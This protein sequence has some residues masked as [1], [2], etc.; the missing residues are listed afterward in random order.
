MK[1]STCTIIGK[2]TLSEW[3]NKW[4]LEKTKR[5]I[6]HVLEWVECSYR[7]VDDF[8]M[9]VLRGY[10]FCPEFGVLGCGVLP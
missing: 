10:G 4:K 8:L 2:E 3:Q 6:R 1:E 5:L 7:K 9:K